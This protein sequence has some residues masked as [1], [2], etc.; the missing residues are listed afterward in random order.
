MDYM[1]AAAA[2]FAQEEEQGEH[3]GSGQTEQEQEMQREQE[4]H[5]SMEGKPV[6]FAPEAQSSGPVTNSVL[7]A[8]VARVASVG[9]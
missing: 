6:K 2:A 8:T 7:A 3:Y 4:A 1:I 5:G 9:G